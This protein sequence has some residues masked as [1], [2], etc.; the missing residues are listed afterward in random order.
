MTKNNNEQGNKYKD[1]RLII[2]TDFI[3]I[4]YK[5]MNDLNGHIN[6]L[7]TNIKT[8]KDISK[9]NVLWG[10]KMISI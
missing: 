5:Q 10:Y 1:P 6:Q 2:N 8:V 7:L 3:L 4:I 9:L